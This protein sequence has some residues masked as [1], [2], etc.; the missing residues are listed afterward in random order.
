MDA[1][2]FLTVFGCLGALYF[3]LALRASKKV[4]T[5]TDYFVASRSLNT[6]QI[7][8]NLIATQLGGGMLLGTAA[9]AY[10]KGYFG[11]LYTLGMALGFIL[12]SCGIASRL[13]Q[14]KV[15]TTAE[16]FET[17][18]GSPTLKK[19]ASLLSIITLFGILIAQVVGFKSLMAAVGFGSGFI[20]LPFWLSVIAYTMIG[21][22]R[23]I[24]IN[25]MVQLGIITATFG[26]IF[27]I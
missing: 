24:T 11:I 9:S 17:Q 19:I 1:L 5:D 6:L 2:L 25:D 27:Y 26:G 12:L 7:T 8:C 23:A 22:L 21:G 13:Q 3:F 4:T 16:L 15:T 20:V 14:F 10:E 18:Y